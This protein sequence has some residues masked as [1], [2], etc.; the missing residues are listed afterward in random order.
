MTKLWQNAE[1]AK[2]KKVVE[3]LLTK[4]G[5]SAIICKLTTSEAMSRASEG[6][7][8][9]SRKKLKKLLKNLLTKSRSCDIIVGRFCEG[10]PRRKIAKKLKKLLKNL[11]TKSRSCDII[12]GRF[13]EMSQRAGSKEPWKIFKK[14]FQKPLDKSKRM[15]YNKRVAQNAAAR[16]I[17]HRSLII[18][19]QEIKVQAK[20]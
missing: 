20:A 6:N 5:D 11:L 9:G 15:W 19:Q 8:K 2:V 17:S 3:N 7:P 18:E 12:V 4:R 16:E 14:T 10:E 13:C 1:E